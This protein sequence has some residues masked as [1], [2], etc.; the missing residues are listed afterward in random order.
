[1]SQP[2]LKPSYDVVI[3]GG[4]AVGSAAA[5]FLAASPDF[6]GSI[7][8]VER[9]WT[10]SRA[11]TALSSASIR[12]QFSNPLNVRISQFGTDFIRHFADHCAVGSEQPDLAF[13]ENGYL[14][15]AADDRGRQA[16]E[17]NHAGPISQAMAQPAPA[18]PVPA[19]PAAPA[20]TAEAPARQPEPRPAADRAA[21]DLSAS[22]NDRAALVATAMEIHDQK[23]SEVKS[24]KKRAFSLPSLNLGRKSAPKVEPELPEA[25]EIAAPE[26][27][28][29]TERLAPAAAAKAEPAA[30][31]H[32]RVLR[33]N[34]AVAPGKPS[35][36][37]PATQTDFI[38]AARR[39]AQAAALASQAREAEEE[40]KAAD[41]SFVE[42]LKKMRKPLTYT[43]IAL[44]LVVGGAQLFGMLSGSGGNKVGS[45][46]NVAPQAT[47]QVAPENTNAVNPAGSAAAPEMSE[48][49][50]PDRVID[51]SGGVPADGPAL[52]VAELEAPAPDSGGSEPAEVDVIGAPSNES[53]SG[54]S[55]ASLNTAPAAPM[56]IASAELPAPGANEAVPAELPEDRFPT[57][58]RE[59]ALAG[60]AAAQFEVADRFADDKAIN[61]DLFRAAEW[62]A[63]A[64]GQGLAPAQ[65]RLGS[66]Y[67]KGQGV[68]KSLDLAKLWYERG[69]LQG[70]RKAMHNLAVLL[71]ND[72]T[73]PD[74]I[75][76]GKWFQMAAQLVLADSQYNLGILRARGLGMEQNIAESYKW[77]ALAADQGDKDATVKRDQIAK[78]LDEESLV[79]ARLA[80]Q[81]WKPQPMNEVANTVPVPAGGWG[82]EPVAAATLSGPDLVREAQS[83]LNIAGFG[84]GTPDGIAGP[85]TQEA[86]RAFQRQA[87]LPESGEIT[88][89]LIK[90]L[91]KSNG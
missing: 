6:S 22:A 13:R 10:Y 50:T 16:L 29:P 36:K 91:S 21:P 79:A 35:D 24:G 42:R 59:A 83:L 57:A 30:P 43:A 28:S 54:D 73:A 81:S 52:E 5:Y 40:S 23:Q 2:A 44:L 17:A 7:L 39:A 41:K 75:N 71:V 60:D 49:R 33:S 19:S 12:H 32:A 34:P 62:Y 74:Y 15:L 70:N 58:L 78:S 77:F 11:A 47:E 69:A 84:V 3:A 65:Y 18:Q 48:A 68:Q 8:V 45:E 4:G 38:A 14:F 53:T 90:H 9:D 56:Q 80:V 25:P 26:I 88:P 72:K 85:R 76:A 61:S 89:D 64:A 66:L 87:G 67:E 1:M 37:A 20:R 86:V 31:T 55:V 63:R 27:P 46:A 82:E 51:A